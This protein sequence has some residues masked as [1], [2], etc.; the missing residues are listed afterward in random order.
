MIAYLVG[1]FLC[2]KLALNTIFLSFYSKIEKSTALKIS[3]LQIALFFVA[4]GIMHLPIPLLRLIFNGSSSIPLGIETRSFM[5]LVNFLD[6]IIADIFAQK[7]AAEWYKNTLSKKE[8]LLS[9]LILSFCAIIITGF[10]LGLYTA[11][12]IKLA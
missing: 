4:F 6:F 3:L 5:Q 2:I 7:Q 9:T 1:M 10:S 12:T 8:L 11:L